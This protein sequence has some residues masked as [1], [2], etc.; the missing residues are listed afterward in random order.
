MNHLQQARS[1]EGKLIPQ[2][3]GKNERKKKNQH[4]QITHETKKTI[5]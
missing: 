4:K 5:L 3:K 2:Q 1:N